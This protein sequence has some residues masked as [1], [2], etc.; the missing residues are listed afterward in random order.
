MKKLFAVATEE[1][2]TSSK[3]RFCIM[4]VG[5]F[6]MF[7]AV[8]T[9]QAGPAASGAG[10][11]SINGEL[12]ALVGGSLWGG[13]FGYCDN[14][15]PLYESCTKGRN[16]WKINIEGAI[17]FPLGSGRFSVGPVLGVAYRGNVRSTYAYT[18]SGTSA[19]I[20]NDRI[21]SLFV[22][23]RV[24]AKLGDRVRA[25]V[26]AGPSVNT[27]RYSDLYTSGT[28][29]S[30]YK[31]STTMTAPEEAIGLTFFTSKHVGLTVKYERLDVRAYKEIYGNTGSMTTYET[32]THENGVVGGLTFWFGDR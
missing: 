24:S 2:M 16:T 21:N 9:A 15:D 1:V 31:Y 11:N 6:L 22:G 12:D 27:D 5:V 23:G 30:N 25:F 32:V 19:D 17:L 29:T 28:Y 4:L 3:L 26:E 18:G 20:Y 7:A 10:S 14:I 13:D 8:S